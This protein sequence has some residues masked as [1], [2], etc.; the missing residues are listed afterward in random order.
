MHNK[1]TF[2]RLCWGLLLGSLY[3]VIAVFPSPTKREDI[4]P[5]KL[6][7]IIIINVPS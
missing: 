6:M 1:Y 3:T 7:Y 4:G 2:I 5:L